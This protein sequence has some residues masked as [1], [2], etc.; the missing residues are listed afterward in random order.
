MF[1]QIKITHQKELW[2][3]KHKSMYLSNIM[4]KWVKMGEIETVYIIENRSNKTRKSKRNDSF[5]PFQIRWFDDWQWWTS[6]FNMLVTNTKMFMLLA[7]ITKKW[8]QVQNEMLT[9]C[10]VQ[11]PLARLIG[12]LV[13]LKDQIHIFQFTNHNTVDDN[14][15]QWKMIT[16]KIDQH[17]HFPVGKDPNTHWES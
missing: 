15:K 3:R 7:D 1:L 8:T 9:S 4:W 17:I 2:L 11:P 5:K 12:P 14:Y 10:G 6:P 16:T 13:L